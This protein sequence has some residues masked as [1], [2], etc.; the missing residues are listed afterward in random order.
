MARNQSNPPDMDRKAAQQAEAAARKNEQDVKNAIEGAVQVRNGKLFGLV[1]VAPEFETVVNT[2]LA[3][4]TVWLAE[5]TSKV[6]HNQAEK[7]FTSSLAA[8]HAPHIVTNAKK[9]AM[10]AELGTMWSILALR[11]L[12]EFF[13]ANKDYTFE[14]Y[15]LGKE[16]KSVCE[17]TGSDV[18]HNEVIKSAYNQ[19]HQQWMTDLKMMAPSLLT[20]AASIPHGINASSDIIANRGFDPVRAKKM[21]EIKQKNP[22]KTDEQLRRQAE[23]EEAREKKEFRSEY[24]SEYFGSNYRPNEYESKNFEEALEKAWERHRQGRSTTTKTDAES[25]FMGAIFGGYSLPTLAGMFGQPMQAYLTNRERENKHNRNSFAL[26]KDLANELEG[27]KDENSIHR[28]LMQIFQQLEEDMGRS[29]FAG[30]LLEKLSESL[31]PVSEA[32]AA[33]RLDAL[34]LVKL[35]GEHKI[36]DHTGGKRSF[37]SAEAIEKAIEEVCCTQVI[38]EHELSEEEFLGRLGSLAK[39]DLTSLIKKNLAEMKDGAEKDFFVAIMP[40][41]V[42]EHAGMKKDEIRAHRKHN[43]KNL[44]EQVAVGIL[45]IAAQEPEIL[46]EHGLSSKEIQHIQQLSKHIVSGDMEAVKQMVDAGDLAPIIS[47]ELLA[48][49]AKGNDKVWTEIVGRNALDKQIDKIKEK[50]VKTHTTSSEEQ[51]EISGHKNAHEEMKQPRTHREH[52]LRGRGHEREGHEF[53]QGV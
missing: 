20:F 6:V 31:K 35:A 53:R 42:L 18:A 39:D 26:I 13:S 17:A 9:Y 41:E 32:I 51:E 49:Q 45:H 38:K 50:H 1:P 10:W 52:A 48:E 36:I 4:A 14:R 7:L 2:L 15:K 5:S 30:G 21:A 46:K 33:G 34:A 8:K 47:S 37:R 25:K 24:R 40:T 28:T 29:K 12:T 23:M 3:P 16:I 19:L 22:N 27:R 43:Y 11:P 44:Y